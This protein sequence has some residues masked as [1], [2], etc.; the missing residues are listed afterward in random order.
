MNSFDITKVLFNYN[1]VHYIDID[2]FRIKYI[3]LSVREKIDI[4]NKYSHLD[5]DDGT[6]AIAK[7][8]CLTMMDKAGMTNLSSL[9][10]LPFFR[11]NVIYKEILSDIH[12]IKNDF[13]K[14]YE[15]NKTQR[16]AS[17]DDKKKKDDVKNPLDPLINMALLTKETNLSLDDISNLD[18]VSLFALMVFMAEVNT[19]E[20]NRFVENE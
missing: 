7:E 8:Q 19:R 2:G 1:T 16:K 15:K 14:F 9:E 20:H 11:L 10:D 18:E 3:P 4:E 6:K 12:D 17:K 5:G 13:S